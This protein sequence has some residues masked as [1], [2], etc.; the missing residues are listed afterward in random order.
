MWP[1]IDQLQ[2]LAAHGLAIAKT[3]VEKVRALTGAEGTYPKITSRW[4]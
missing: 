1:F 4:V 3:C 2:L